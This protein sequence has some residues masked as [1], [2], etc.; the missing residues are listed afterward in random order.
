M[1][2]RHSGWSD[3]NA[4]P[5]QM[6]SSSSREQAWASIFILWISFDLLW[7]ADICRDMEV[8]SLQLHIAW[9]ESGGISGILRVS[10][11]S[12]WAH[13]AFRKPP[14]LMLFAS[15]NVMF[16]LM[17]SSRT[18]SSFV[19]EGLGDLGG[20]SCRS[21]RSCSWKGKETNRELQE[22]NQCGVIQWC[23]LWGVTFESF[24]TWGQGPPAQ[25]I[26]LKRSEQRSWDIYQFVCS[27]WILQLCL[28]E[29][30]TDL[31]NNIWIH[32]N[33]IELSYSLY[34]IWTP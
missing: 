30:D 32:M 16:S 11:L 19:G 8:C 23:D 18:M 1:G 17:R 27:I 26:W 13:V 6:I 31:W 2:R 9:R 25:Q 7:F 5:Y 4:N 24:L 28:N 15:Q 33:Y 3:W 10:S 29:N 14:W 20:L 34:D 22:G 12:S 21:C